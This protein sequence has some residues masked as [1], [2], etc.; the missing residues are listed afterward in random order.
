MLDWLTAYGSG[1]QALAAIADLAVA[2]ALAVLTA[3]YVRLTREI[4]ESGVEQSKRFNASF[5]SMR[6]REALN[7][8]ALARRIRV[9]LAQLTLDG[10]IHEQLSRYPHLG[11]RDMGELMM[12]AVD[13][14]REAMSVATKAADALYVVNAAIQKAYSNRSRSGMEADRAREGRIG[15]G[16]GVELCRTCGV[17]STL[18]T[19]RR[20]TS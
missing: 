11:D 18:S 8:A 14:D 7:L 1:L 6:R 12:S 10:S 19:I 3:R 20:R 2:A 4:A 16:F 15:S 13:V 9:P 5:L 17:R